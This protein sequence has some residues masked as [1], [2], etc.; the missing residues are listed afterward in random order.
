M[1]QLLPEESKR[2]C[3]GRTKTNR[4]L[5]IAT[6]AARLALAEPLVMALRRK[7]RTCPKTTP[8]FSMGKHGSKCG[9]NFGRLL[10]GVPKGAIDSMEAL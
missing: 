10:R 5:F 2:K 3:L 6:A 8:H 7:L 4:K 9:L 1:M